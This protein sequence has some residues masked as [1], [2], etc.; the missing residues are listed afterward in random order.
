MKLSKYFK[1][2]AVSLSLAIS[3]NP[4]FAFASSSSANVTDQAATNVQVI[5]SDPYEEG[6]LEYQKS[7]INQN[8]S[9]PQAR[10]GIVSLVKVVFKLLAKNADDVVVTATKKNVTTTLKNHAI[11]QAVARGITEIMLDNILSET[12]VSMLRVLKFEDVLGQSRIMYD[13]G[14]KL[15]VVLSLVDNII[16]TTYVDNDNTMPNRVNAGRWKPSTFTFR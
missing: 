8:E 5:S 10:A 6:L 14:S 13:P 3:I 4:I 2:I 16:I 1:F 7:Q 12:A 15:T 9:D 11:K